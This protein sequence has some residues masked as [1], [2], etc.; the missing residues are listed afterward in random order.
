MIFPIAGKIILFCST[1]IYS[2]VSSSLT[3]SGLSLN[4]PEYGAHISK[5]SFLPI[6]SVKISIFIIHDVL[7]Y[8][9]L[10]IH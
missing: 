1:N 6:C 3:S 10:I 9:N 7:P 8:V 4:Q 5:T 2:S